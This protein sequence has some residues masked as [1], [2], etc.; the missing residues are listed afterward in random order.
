VSAVAFVRS[1]RGLVAAALLA[2]CAAPLAAEEL[3]G[4]FYFGA[5]VSMADHSGDQ[6]GIAFDDTPV[7]ATLYGGAQLSERIAIE[8]SLLS[9]PRVSSGELLGSGVSRLKVDSELN[10]VVVRGVFSLYLGDGFPRAARWTLFGTAG[11][12]SSRESRSVAELTTVSASSAKI[13]D[14]GVALGAGVL[15]DLERLRLRAAFEQRGG[16]H[17]DQTAIG[18]SAEFRF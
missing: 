8:G 7:G 15:Y 6:E 10:V 3:D 17:T 5:G 14:S 16:R 1:G 2:C 4:R 13:D 11:G 12:F 9:F 18:V